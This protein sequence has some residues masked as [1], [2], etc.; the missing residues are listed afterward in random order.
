MGGTGEGRGAVVSVWTE[1]E[2]RVGQDSDLRPVV[3][4]DC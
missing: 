1:N 4:E 3:A 2:E